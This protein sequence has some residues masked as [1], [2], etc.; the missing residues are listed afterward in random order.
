MT[1]SAIGALLSALWIV[2]LELSDPL[3]AALRPQSP[4]LEHM[5]EWSLRESGTFRDL[6]RH[7]LQNNVIV[8]L[9]PG[10]CDLGRR[11]AC[12]QHR[13]TRAGDHR[14]LFVIVREDVATM[15]LAGLIAHELQHAVEVADAGVTSA[16]AFAPLF[17]RLGQPCEQ[18]HFQGCYET[19]AAIA[20]QRRVVAELTGAVDSRRIREKL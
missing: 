9:V 11:E 10:R 8:W 18:Q 13:I 5:V 6:A 16:N 7:L 14:F 4:R 19:E 20:A 17:E 15:R 1:A 12:L 2:C 3:A